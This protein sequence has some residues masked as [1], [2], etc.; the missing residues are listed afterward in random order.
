MPSTKLSALTAL[1]A[2]DLATSDKL[3]VADTSETLSKSITATALASGLHRLGPTRWRDVGIMLSTARR[4]AITLPTSADSASITSAVYETI[5]GNLQD[6]LPSPAAL[7]DTGVPDATGYPAPAYGFDGPNPTI[8]L[9]NSGFKN[10]LGWGQSCPNTVGAM[11]EFHVP[12]DMAVVSGYSTWR[13]QARMVL[14]GTGTLSALKTMRFRMGAENGGPDGGL[15][16]TGLYNFGPYQLSDYVFPA[17]SAP[18]DYVNYDFDGSAV[19]DSNGRC[20]KP[21][22]R[23]CLAAWCKETQETSVQT[24]IWWLNFRYLAVSSPDVP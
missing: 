20:L 15:S 13:L 16:P 3:Y 22:D 24:Q 14:G 17:T 21:G 11:F 7:I 12:Y 9:S 10:W 23:V 6:T 2:A 19:Q 8:V 18:G 5:R 4:V 1:D